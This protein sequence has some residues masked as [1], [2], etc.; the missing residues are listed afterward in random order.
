MRLADAIAQV[1]VSS[2]PLLMTLIVLFVVFSWIRV[3]VD[4]MSGRDF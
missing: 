3:L 1:F 2:A 4:Y